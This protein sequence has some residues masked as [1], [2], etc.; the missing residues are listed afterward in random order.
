MGL[1]VGLTGGIGAGKSEV[2]RVFAEL[3]AYIIDTDELAREAV[4]PNSDG[5]LAIAH[6]WPQFVRGGALDRAALAEVVFSDPQALARLNEIVHPF[7]RRL[8]KEREANAKPDQLIVHVVPLLF[9]SGYIDMVD[10][11]V[12]VIAPL[13]ERI[14]RVVGRDQ[15]DAEH[16]LARMKT[17]IDPEEA[18]ARADYVIENN[19]DLEHL[20]EQ[21]RAVYDALAGITH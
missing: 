11:S 14:A 2:A 16:I 7:V 18:R 12:V 13:E 9:E 15:T 6:T 19:G 8:A 5:L 3:G 20:R 17:Q 4:A 1:R 21:T 10:K